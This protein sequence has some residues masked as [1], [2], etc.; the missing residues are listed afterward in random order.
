MLDQ[1]GEIMTK[2]IIGLVVGFVVLAVLIVAAAAFAERI[3]WA[4]GKAKR[5][6]LPENGRGPKWL[7]A[8]RAFHAARDAQKKLTDQQRS[9]LAAVTQPWLARST[10]PLSG[11]A[12]EPF[13]QSI[14]LQLAKLDAAGVRTEFDFVPHRS[15]NARYR[16]PDRASDGKIERGVASVFGRVHQVWRSSTGRQL[17]SRKLA[18]AELQFTLASGISSADG[19]E[20]TCTSCGHP[21]E[22]PNADAFT[23]PACGAIM[24]REDYQELVTGFNVFPA[25]QARK[26][27]RP[28]I[29]IA[30]S[31][32]TVLT[33]LVGISIAID[34][35]GFSR[36]LNRVQELVGPRAQL[37]IMLLVVALSP[38]IFRAWG[39]VSS[40]RARV[41]AE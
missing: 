8:R 35:S 3:S 11:V 10:G 40:H 29:K 36:V 32:S 41:A 39:R 30:I 24:R 14:R 21:I 1:V 25:E 19:L 38:F 22:Q 13:Q 15:V 20:Y 26:H 34:P 9:L 27:A 7:R 12:T 31:A 4:M 16:D 33:I 5:L 6:D 23:C 28:V 2:V 18:D 37:A 17:A